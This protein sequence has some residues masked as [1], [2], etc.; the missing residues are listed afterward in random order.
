MPVSVSVFK[1]RFYCHYLWLTLLVYCLCFSD[2]KEKIG[3][4]CQFLIEPKA[5]E[6]MKHQY[7]YG[8][9]VLIDLSIL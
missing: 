2:Y 1:V 7:D 9:L 6:P 8:E 5:K 4:K 3:L